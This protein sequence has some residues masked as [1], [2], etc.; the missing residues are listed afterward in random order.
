MGQG[1]TATQITIG[2]EV[3]KDINKATAAVGAKTD[4]PE[5]RAVAQATIDYLNAHGGIAGRKIV[6]V[7]SLMDPTQGTFESQAQQTCSRFTE[8][9][10]V[11]AAVSSSVGGNDSLASCLAQR[12]VPLVANNY[13]PFDAA[14]YGRLGRFLYQP[15]RMIQERWVPAFIDGLVS[16][17]FFTKGAK[18]GII[19]F[20]EPVFERM[21][22][23][24]KQRLAQHGLQVTAEAATLT[25]HAI[26]DFGAMGAQIGNAIINFQSKRVT[27]I[28]MAEYNG[29]LPFFFLPAADSQGYKPV[30]GF[31][32]NDLPNT[33]AGGQAPQQLKGSMVVGWMPANDVG[34]DSEYRKGNYALCM[35][36]VKNA[37]GGPQGRRLY[38]P[39]YCDSLMFLKTA[40]ERAG[41]LTADG[42]DAAVG[43]LGR[44][45]DSP[46]TYATNLFPGRHD[47]AGSVRYSRF[48]DGCGCY[49]YANDRADAVG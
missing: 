30:Y 38:A 47:G 28:L 11:F 3:A 46:F 14:E 40:L 17:G 4:N 16:M 41:A 19:R 15:G 25:P 7:W 39:Y 48:D 37:G 22:A 36:I 21:A 8:D 49:V 42:L 10:H 2:V 32:S 35:D 23:A 27:H 20:D 31:H 24:M 18:I 33:Q 26:A 6:P 29:Q 44:S 9:A 13:W 45:Y 1:V 12:G 34:I 43:G 5:E